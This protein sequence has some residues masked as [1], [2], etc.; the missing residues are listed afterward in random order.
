MYDQTFDSPGNPLRAGIT[1]AR[2]GK[3]SVGTKRALR[4]NDWM[5]WFRR[6]R[7]DNVRHAPYGLQAPTSQSGAR[8]LWGGRTIV[9]PPA[10]LMSCRPR[11]PFRCGAGGTIS[12]GPYLAYPRRGAVSRDRWSA[13]L[14]RSTYG[15]RV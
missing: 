3:P 10:V 7:A 14:S 13:W 2:P 9:H 4:P 12:P 6:H 8:H 11:H 5:V 15:E 1:T